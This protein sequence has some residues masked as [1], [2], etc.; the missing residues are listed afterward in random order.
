MPEVVEES[1][2]YYRD[3]FHYI[4][5][6]DPIWRRHNVINKDF[7]RKNR[8]TEIGHERERFNN[9]ITRGFRQATFY[10][11]VQDNWFRLFALGFL[12]RFVNL[13]QTFNYTSSSFAQHGFNTTLVASFNDLRGG[14]G[15]MRGPFRGTLL[16]FY[17]WCGTYYSAYTMAKGCASNF[18]LN[19]VM[20]ETLWHP[21][22]TLRTRYVADGRMEYKS[23]TDVLRTTNASQVYNGL[24]YKLIWT[25]ALG[26]AM[27]NCASN[28]DSKLGM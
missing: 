18:M 24:A 16:G 27:M 22:D 4:F 2:T 9:F 1:V 25:G 14:S 15:L 11:V 23:F 20:L 10:D 28:G 21:F 5:V 26:F 8:L 17:Q 19:L 13:R 7:M 12:E 6:E 3:W